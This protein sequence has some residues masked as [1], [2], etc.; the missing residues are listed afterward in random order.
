MCQKLRKLFFVFLLL[1]FSLAVL[2][3]QDLEPVITVKKSE[4]M[5][6]RNELII[7][8]EN[9]RLKENSVQEL[10][11]ALDGQQERSLILQ[12]KIESLQQ[13]IDEL[14]TASEISKQ[15]YQKILTEWKTLSDDLTKSL[16][17]AE[18]KVKNRKWWVVL[19]FVLGGALGFLL[20][21]E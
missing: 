5:S 16:E 12:K 15:E 10:L 21:D 13:N 6:I 1:C 8:R 14:L 3:P 7:L 11:T 19:A 4:L 18:R 2:L 9:L 20:G 17:I